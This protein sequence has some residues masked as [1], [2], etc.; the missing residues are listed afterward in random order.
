MLLLEVLHDIL[1]VHNI[2]MYK[3]KMFFL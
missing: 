1:N 3:V 2:N